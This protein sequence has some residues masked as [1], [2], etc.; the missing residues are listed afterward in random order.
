MNPN[1][2]RVKH[3][4]PPNRVGGGN[5]S[6]RPPHHPACGSAQGG[7]L[8]WSNYAVSCRLW[9]LRC[10]F[11]PCRVADVRGHGT[12]HCQGWLLT[13]SP[14]RLAG[15]VGLHRWSRDAA[16]SSLY[17]KVRSFTVSSALPEA[18]GYYDLG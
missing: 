4:L 6:P 1:Q 11:P 8:R 9:A 5:F 7:S 3:V 15:P 13:T 12:L 17:G 16:G 18:L 2:N 10:P 14:T